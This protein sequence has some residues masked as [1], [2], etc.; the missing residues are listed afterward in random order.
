MNNLLIK[1]KS[2]ALDGGIHGT[3][4]YWNVNVYNCF[5]VFCNLIANFFHSVHC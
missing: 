3:L 2:V 4:V 1:Q 5:N